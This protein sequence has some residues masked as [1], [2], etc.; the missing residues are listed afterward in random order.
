MTKYA[1]W[2]TTDVGNI[3]GGRLASAL[4]HRFSG[5]LSALSLSDQKDAAFAEVLA[6]TP[7]VFYVNTFGAVGNGVAYDDVAINDALGADGRTVEFEAGATYLLSSDVKFRSGQ[8]LIGNGAVIKTDA[9]IK[10]LF[11]NLDIDQ[12]SYNGGSNIVIEGFV[13]DGENTSR[14]IGFIGLAHSTNVVIR[15]C[16]FRD[17]NSS[18][19]LHAIDAAGNEHLTI[20]NCLFEDVAGATTLQIDAATSGSMPTFTTPNL[21]T[22]SATRSHD[23]IIKNNYFLRCGSASS[24]FQ[25]VH[26]HKKGHNRIHIIDNHFFDCWAA[27]R[28]DIGSTYRPN[29]ATTD[30]VIRGNEIDMSSSSSLAGGGILLDFAQRVSIE[31]NIIRGTGPGIALLNYTA[32]INITGITKA[33]PAVVTATAHGLANGYI[34]YI[35]SVG[36]MT[37]VNGKFYKIANKTTNTLEL[38]EIFDGANVNSSGFGTYTSGGTIQYKTFS[39][40][41]RNDDVVIRGNTI[42]AST[43]TAI[44]IENGEN[45]VVT[46]NVITDFG[47]N[48]DHRAGVRIDKGVRIKVSGNIVRSSNSGT[49]FGVAL[50][51]SYRY[52]ITDNDLQNT[53][54]AIFVRKMDRTQADFGR[55]EGNHL[56]LGTA[57]ML[58][59]EGNTTNVISCVTISGNT[60]YGEFS[61]HAI[62]VDRGTRLT[63]QGN[64][65]E[66]MKIT[67]PGISLNIVTNSSVIG[68]SVSAIAAASVNGIHVFGGGGG[69]V[70]I[71]GNFVENYDEGITVD[72]SADNGTCVGNTTKD[73]TTELALAA[74]VVSGNNDSL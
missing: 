5:G 58:Y 20:E 34:I 16:V 56:D 33:N 49:K 37:Q 12:T 41:H 28:D 19:G 67:S 53:S 18:G 44:T 13:F 21:E 29:G 63:V 38:T 6:A 23:I 40:T 32:P 2:P 74:G 10:Y 71:V 54:V 17:L 36:G 39:S 64:S 30:L 47:E 7:N 26:L 42:E 51:R 69:N 43:S 52:A 14:D 62:R 57:F 48:D 65:M 8:R 25:A 4:H 70:N 68:N 1:S 50:Y 59:L 46:D 27:I 45:L 3:V 55:I 72:T 9:A 15:N 31:G 66:D 61:G 22:A 11:R 73:C 60:F 24:S 35:K